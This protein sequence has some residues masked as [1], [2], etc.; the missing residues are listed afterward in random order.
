MLP[1]VLHGLETCSLTLG[2]LRRNYFMRISSYKIYQENG[3]NYVLWKFTICTFK[4]RP[5]F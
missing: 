4:H 3:E 1:A 2:C 5:Y